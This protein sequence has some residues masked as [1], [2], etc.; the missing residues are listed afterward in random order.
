MSLTN[1]NTNNYDDFIIEID[2]YYFRILNKQTLFRRQVINIYSSKDKNELIKENINLDKVNK[3]SVY[4]SKSEIGCF[5]LCLDLAGQL[6][7]GR[8]DKDGSDDY[9]QQTFIHI[10]LQ[11]FIHEC[12]SLNNLIDITEKNEEDKE[13]KKDKKDKKDK[14]DKEDSHM[15]FCTINYKV[16]YKYSEH[17]KENQK[18][19]NGKE[20]QNIEKHID[21]TDRKIKK[22]PFIE[23]LENLENDIKKYSNNKCGHDNM[24]SSFV[25]VNK[26]LNEFSKKLEKIYNYSNNKSITNIII[27][28][29]DNVYNLKFY[30]VELKLKEQNIDNLDNIILYYCNA[31]ITK[32][33]N[34]V[35]GP[36]YI[37]LPVF[38]TTEEGDKI[39][40]FGTYEKYILA[41]NYICK[42]FDYSDQCSRDQ[43]GKCYGSYLLIGNR[44]DNIFPLK[45]INLKINISWKDELS[46]ENMKKIID[47]ERKER[48]LK[49]QASLLASAIP[50]PAIPVIPASVTTRVIS[51]T[52][53]ID[54]LKII[55]DDHLTKIN[56]LIK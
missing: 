28:E 17:S 5:R 41:G 37:N 15:C 49:K 27:N 50:V 39:T 42:I 48:E 1:T 30:K 25:E 13:D 53:K 44:Y 29:N 35:L 21:E 51:P 12:L 54:K 23:Y 26:N 33:L 40:K 20:H 55:I 19:L 34:H 43:L 24:K 36:I 6:Y 14:E 4:L 7:K 11:Q 45:E 22:K 32:F 8:E 47:E 52:N 3:F 2:N 31:K 46:D 18:Y 16:E 9:I 38:L 10:K 56:N